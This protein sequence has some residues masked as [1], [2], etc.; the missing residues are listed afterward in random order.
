MKKIV[1]VIK[2]GE[3][4]GRRL[5]DNET[6]TDKRRIS[7]WDETASG[8]E[9]VLE[10][11]S[12]P[13]YIQEKTLYYKSFDIAGAWKRAKVRKLAQQKNMHS[14]MRKLVWGAAA[15]VTVLLSVT[16]YFFQQ[17]DIVKE[18]VEVHQAI[19]NILPGR[20]V[21]VLYL[22]DDRQIALNADTLD[23]EGTRGIEVGKKMI[24][25][26]KDQIEKE[27]KYNLTLGHVSSSDDDFYH[28]FSPLD[29]VVTNHFDETTRH[30][31]VD[32]VAKQNS[33]VLS[34]LDGVVIFTDWT[35]KTGYVIQVQHN[36]N[37]V[38]VYKHN[39][40]LLKKQGDFVRAGEAIAV[41]GN[42]GEETTGPHLH[43]E[44]W[45]AGKALNPETFIKFK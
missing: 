33:N 25:Y 32:L 27:E 24:T 6:E 14:K 19:V 20:G 35:I 39:S 44:L 11:L 31:G 15:A 9:E 4:V 21:P 41:V 30:Y 13:D 18:N 23:I 3:S 34:V 36:G 37:L 16:V 10:K 43:F 17:D 22:D 7:D 12:D 2:L 5:S 45:Q 26:S 1:D 8:K 29:G 28:F 38:S 42:T 40:V